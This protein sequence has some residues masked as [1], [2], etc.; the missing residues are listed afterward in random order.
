VQSSVDKPIYPLNYPENKRNKAWF[1]ELEDGNS[2]SFSQAK[3]QERA[4]VNAVAVVVVSNSTTVSSD[5][6][7]FEI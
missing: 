3:S 1:D 7:V 2:G 4:A 6:R 5:T